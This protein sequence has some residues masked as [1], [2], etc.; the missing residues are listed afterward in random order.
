MA[1]R[2][3]VAGRRK[4]PITINLYAPRATFVPPP[5]P[6][7]ERNEAP[8]EVGHGT[9]S[10]KWCPGLGREVHDCGRTCPGCVCRRY[11]GGER[12]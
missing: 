4:G 6:P 1:D 12:P 9:P 8:I 2:V 11:E 5:A 10:M 3:V 7:P